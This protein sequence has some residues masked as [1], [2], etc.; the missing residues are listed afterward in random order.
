MEHLGQHGQVGP[1]GPFLCCI[2]DIMTY[3]TFSNFVVDE[4]AGGGAARL[5]RL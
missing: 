5:A 4:Q 2:T 3:W 1:N